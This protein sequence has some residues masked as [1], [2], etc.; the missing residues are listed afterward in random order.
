MNIVLKCLF[1]SEIRNRTIQVWR[2]KMEKFYVTRATHSIMK[3]VKE[4][5]YT[6]ITG[7]S[8]SGKT[9]NAY[10]TALQLQQ[11]EGFVVIPANGP[12]DFIKSAVANTKQIYI[13]DDALGKHLFDEYQFNCWEKHSDNIHGLGMRSPHNTKVIIICRSHLYDKNKFQDLGLPIVHFNMNDPDYTLSLQERREIAKLYLSDETILNLNDYVIMLYNFFPLLC[14]LFSERGGDNIDFFIKPEYFVETVIKKFKSTHDSA[15]IALAL[16]VVCSNQIN[17]QLLQ[18]GD[19]RGVKMIND[20]I[21]ESEL[22]HRPS[23]KLIY[24]SMERLTSTY[25]RETKSYFTSIHDRVFDMV[26]QYIGPSF[27]RSILLHGESSFIGNR[28]KF[29]S[30]K[31]QDDDLLIGVPRE[32][33]ELYFSRMYDDL[34]QGLN[35][36]VFNNVQTKYT[37]YRKCFV[38][39]LTNIPCIEFTKSVSDGSTALHVSSSRGYLNF[40]KFIVEKDALQV[41]ATDDQGRAPLHEA[42]LNGHLDLVEYLI[43]KNALVD[44]QD[45]NLETPLLFAVRCGNLKVAEILIKNGADVNKE[46]QRGWTPIRAACFHGFLDLAKFLFVSNADLNH[47]DEAKFTP[48]LVACCNGHV[49]I[50]KFLLDHDA[51]VNI[52]DSIYWAC[53]YGYVDVVKILVDHSGRN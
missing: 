38:E 15:Y 42:S 1:F 16:L 20:I 8:G 49:D 31:E 47:K 2:R 48:L 18:I 53:Q 17:K 13:F 3:I 6:V 23:K 11:N 36:T 34:K 22:N 12:D 40:A 44:N 25:L 7:I 26:S 32:S 39:Y 19:Q 5:Q 14:E 52:T 28:L 27:I 50:V 4:N 35:W 51:A 24:T 21:E 29:E 37:K 30:I 41:N 43:N 45:T 10:Y 9:I 46:N 33:E